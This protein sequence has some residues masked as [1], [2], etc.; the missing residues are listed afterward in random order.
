MGY[1]SLLT[2]G[3]PKSEKEDDLMAWIGDTLM[4]A[5]GSLIGDTADGLFRLRNGD[6]VNGVAKLAPAKIVGDIAKA[7]E[8]Y[9]KA[10]PTSA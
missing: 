4:G 1:A 7:Y 2:F 10:S 5:P 3:Q 6:Y 9:N 8:L